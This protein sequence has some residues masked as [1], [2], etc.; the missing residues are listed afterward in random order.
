MLD[1]LIQLLYVIN[2][3]NKIQEISGIIRI[4]SQVTVELK[5]HSRLADLAVDNALIWFGPG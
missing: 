3:E 1:N 2:K 5:Q 4:H